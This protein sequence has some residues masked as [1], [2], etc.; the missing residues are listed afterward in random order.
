MTYFVSNSIGIF[1]CQ[2]NRNPNEILFDDGFSSVILSIFFNA[3]R[4]F[5]MHQW[6]ISLAFSNFFNSAFHKIKKK[7]LNLPLKKALSYL[8]IESWIEMLKVICPLYQN[9][10][11]KTSLSNSTVIFKVDESIDTKKKK[12]QALKTSFLKSNY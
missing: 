2:Q 7:G 8:I 4:I 5:T 1:Q 12:K 3:N 10:N 9:Y 11:V 6:N